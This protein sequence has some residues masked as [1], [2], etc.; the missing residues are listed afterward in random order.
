MNQVN[1]LQLPKN[2]REYSEE[3]KKIIEPRLFIERKREVLYLLDT[4]T[5]LIKID[6]IL[7]QEDLL[8]FEKEFLKKS[9]E[10]FSKY[11][12]TS[13]FVYIKLEEFE[14]LIKLGFQAFIQRTEKIKNN[15]LEDETSLYDD[16]III[17]T[18]FII[19]NNLKLM[20]ELKEKLI[21]T[22]KVNKIQKFVFLFARSVLNLVLLY[23]FFPKPNEDALEEINQSSLS[24]WD[25]L[26][27]SIE[28]LTI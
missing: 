24:L 23:S 18:L 6:K 4:K 28:E 2:Y 7:E 11:L 15:I 26:H 12:T 3:A 8:K 17:K 10:I 13:N 27:P 20:S 1:F 25:E 14:E 16:P 19:E 21:G 5:F 9:Y 22:K